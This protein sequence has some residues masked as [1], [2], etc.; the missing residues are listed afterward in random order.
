[1]KNWKKAWLK[2]LD[3]ITPELSDEVKSAPISMGED[4]ISFDG[5]TAVKSRKIQKPLVLV[6]VAVLL[7]LAILGTVF[8]IPKNQRVGLFSVEI[9]P[10]VSFSTDGN[11]VVTGVR[12]S[13]RDADVLLA[14]KEITENLVGKNIGD[15][16]KLYVDY[17]AQAGYI[18]LNEIGSAVRVSGCLDKK[19]EKLLLDV[20]DSLKKYFT[21]KGAYSVVVTDKVDVKEFCSR[22]GISQA[23]SV[24]EVS[25]N[26]IS[27]ETLVLVREA[28]GMSKEQLQNQYKSLIGD[29]GEYIKNNLKANIEIV[30]QSAEDIKKIYDLNEEIELHENN[31]SYISLKDYW[32]VKLLPF[33]SEYE[34]SFG[35]LMARM[36]TSLADYHD[37]YGVEISNVL[38]LKSA[39]LN[40]D[41]LPVPLDELSIWV[42][43]LSE[44]MAEA[45][46]EIL[47]DVMEIAGVLDER[48]AELIELPT[49]VA[50][51]VEKTA[52]VLQDKLEKRISANSESYHKLRDEISF[53]DYDNYVSELIAEYGS[54][55]DYWFATKK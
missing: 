45:L 26:I 50:E 25:R 28:S 9:N 4:T 32:S 1:M 33:I 52:A 42:D 47:S 48:F 21:S 36:E 49:T 6:L 13:N 30:K 39:K 10:S 51:Y 53:S 23:S 17:A 12:A 5:E 38:V 46:S 34:E 40:F 31:P 54:L 27:S 16:V 8:L 20:S 18:D 22:S 35:N 41:K 11:G 55:D 37:K 24:G 3:N 15:A 7:C 43:G 19:A 14:S 2:E 44:S 29:F